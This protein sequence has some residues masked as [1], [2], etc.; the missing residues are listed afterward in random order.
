MNKLR[1]SP[2]QLKILRNHAHDA[3]MFPKLELDKDPQGMGMPFK[4]YIVEDNPH[5]LVGRIGRRVRY[6]FPNGYGASVVMGGLF[7]CD[8]ERPYE[9]GLLR[10][11]RLDYKVLGNEYEDV[12][13]YQTDAD[14]MI[15]LAKLIS[16]P[17]EQA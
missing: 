4:E 10:E 16:L 6:D 3:E 12:L 1:I 7:H 17:K 5:H 8:A 2:T 13:G 11:G 9:I 14:L 15:V